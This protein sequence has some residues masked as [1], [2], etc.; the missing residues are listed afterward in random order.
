MFMEL[1]RARA[2]ADGSCFEK[3]DRF[4]TIKLPIVDDFM[5]TPISTQ[6]AAGRFSIRAAREGKRATLIAPQLEPEEWYLRIEGELM[7]DSILNRIATASRYSD[8][9]GPN[10]REY[11]AKQKETK[12]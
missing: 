7:A 12:E 2:H 9:E 1:N 11:F 5:T 8:I 4:K 6:A 10:M 3:M